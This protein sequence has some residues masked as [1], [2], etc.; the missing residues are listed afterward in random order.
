MT[1]HSLF[2][3]YPQIHH[4][5]ELPQKSKKTTPDE[6]QGILFDG[7]S[8]YPRRAS[9]S[10]PPRNSRPYDQGLLTIGFL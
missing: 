4:Q 6:F 1:L 5:A 8:T 2:A 9:A 10:H 7:W 3:Y